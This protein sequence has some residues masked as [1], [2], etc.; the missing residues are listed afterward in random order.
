MNEQIVESITCEA[1]KKIEDIQKDIECA[2]EY[3]ECEDYKTHLQSII[4]D[5]DKIIEQLC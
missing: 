1:I 4:D 5:L 3:S 2:I